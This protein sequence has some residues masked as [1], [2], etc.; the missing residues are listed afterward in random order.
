MAVEAT[1][2]NKVQYGLKN[3][4]IATVTDDGKQLTYEETPWRLHGAV[5]MSLD[6]AGESTPFY[7]DDTIYYM[8]TSNQGYT[9]KLTVA[10]INDEF[11]EKIL[12]E[13]YDKNGLLVES[14][15]GK[16]K[17]FAMM[18]EFD[19]DQKATRHVLY[20]V[21]VTRP[22]MS[23]KTKEDKVEADTQELEF[24]AAPDPYTGY[25]KSKS[26]VKTSTETYDAWYSKVPVPD[27]TAGA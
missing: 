20:N 4:Y 27:F 17:S 2:E 1:A 16:Q 22:S 3:V 25:A 21:S 14:N 12:G 5:E 19:G 6:P 13:T 8:A 24:T 18:F 15:K 23:G 7:A 26:T 11:R 9:G 10:L